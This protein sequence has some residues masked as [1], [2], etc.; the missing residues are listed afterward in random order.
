M[1]SDD[2]KAGNRQ[3]RTLGFWLLL[4]GLVVSGYLVFLPIYD[5]L[6]GEKIVSYSPFGNYLFLFTFSSSMIL[7]LFGERGRDFMTHKLTRNW[8]ITSLFVLL[9]LAI[10]YFIQVR[11]NRWLPVIK[12]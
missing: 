6:Q 7:V 8:I 12:G 10:G 4:I 2:L 5:V 3:A 1:Q 11:L 9:I